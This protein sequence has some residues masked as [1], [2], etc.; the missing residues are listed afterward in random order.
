MD[1]QLTAHWV[2]V[3]KLAKGTG[4]TPEELA[5]TVQE[6]ALPGL[7]MGGEWGVYVKLGDKPAEVVVRNIDIGF[8]R[9]VEL[10]VKFALAII[11][12]AV[13]LGFI[14]FGGLSILRFLS[15]M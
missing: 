15:M 11:P 8:W 5:R 3:D 9:M 13:L 7:K 4:R 6:G 12:A 1:K 2:P 14:V 10:M